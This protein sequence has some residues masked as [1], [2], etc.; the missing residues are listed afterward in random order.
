MTVVSRLS[1]FLTDPRTDTQPAA[2]SKDGLHH[3]PLDNVIMVINID[4]T[5]FMSNVR[6]GHL[7][8]IHYPRSQSRK[9][10]ARISNESSRNC[11]YI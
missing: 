2:L 7:P 11:Q 3:T 6:L 4:V 5:V 9:R 1:P 10:G 8:P